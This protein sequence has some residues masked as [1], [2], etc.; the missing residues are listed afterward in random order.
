[1]SAVV[2]AEAR[3]RIRR[4]LVAMGA[5]KDVKK[6]GVAVVEPHTPAIVPARRAG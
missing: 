3:E 5:I 2:T 6:A 4:N 1:M